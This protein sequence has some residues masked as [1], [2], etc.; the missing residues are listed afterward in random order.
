MFQGS[1]NESCF[2]SGRNRICGT[3]IGM[4]IIIKLIF[5]NLLF[6]SCG[7]GLG[8]A[9][10]DLFDSIE[11]HY[12]TGVSLD[13]GVYESIYIGKKV[14]L[15]AT[16]YPAN[17][18]DTKVSWSII[19][20][21]T[22]ATIDSESGVVSAGTIVGTI[23]VQAVTREG[24]FSAQ[25]TIAITD[26]I[27][28]D[29]TSIIVSDGNLQPVFNRTQFSY[30]DAPV[31]YIQTDP[32]IT[33]VAS[34]GGS[35]IS[36]NGVK[37]ESGIPYTVAGVDTGSNIL[38]VVLT[39]ADG[40]TLNTYTVHLYRA[41]PVYKTGAAS[42]PGY[43]L[44]QRED[45]AVQRGVTW[46][47]PRFI[48]NGDETL[49]DKLSGLV[50]MKDLSYF[51]PAL[52]WD[53]GLASCENL[54]YA[55]R[56]DWRL[57]NVRDLLSVKNWGEATYGWLHAS[58]FTGLQ[59][60]LQCWSSTVDP[61]NSLRAWAIGFESFITPHSKDS[62]LYKTLWPVRSGSAI[63]RTGQIS[64]MPGEDGFYHTGVEA[65]LIRIHDNMDGT[66]SDN[67]TGLVWLQNADIS[68]GLISWKDGFDFVDQLNKGTVLGNCGYK[69]WRIPTINEIA[70]LIDY[71][72]TDYFSTYQGLLQFTNIPGD[73]V[74]S[75]LTST[76]DA[77]L[78]A[79][80]WCLD[81][82]NGSIRSISKES[83]F[84]LLL[85]RDSR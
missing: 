57:P 24:G 38:S 46:P 34:Q 15:R 63:Q 70:S 52:D 49:T 9:Y 42:I 69:D 18:T 54:T 22:L 4:R 17:A 20:G 65:P 2:Y 64:G 7:E 32:R 36:I 5:I 62:G 28:Y 75:Y 27:S 45:G 31:P 30:L 53:T 12:V 66:L 58:G 60:N 25:R 14:K 74:N 84:H 1:A 37:A 68:N 40:I 56:T 76:T 67:Y 78:P 23:T 73:W 19:G 11:H 51:V 50:W 29:L 72:S 71:G 13:I 8:T 48:D 41:I 55:G 35:V 83:E 3:V 43:T 10:K 80:V 47:N 79:Q 21:S 16:V 39:A 61:M 26:V 33:P 85:V 81:S 82:Y 44:D 6:V 77:K 59:V